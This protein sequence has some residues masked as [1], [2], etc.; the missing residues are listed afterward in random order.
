MTTEEKLER[1]QR[2]VDK[3]LATLPN[4]LPKED[5]D[6]LKDIV[7]NTFSLPELR[8]KGVQERLERRI[9]ELF[10][11]KNHDDGET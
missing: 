1:Y 9:E 11:D 8:I 2:Y 10:G 5:R 6:I 7:H 4:T 3:H